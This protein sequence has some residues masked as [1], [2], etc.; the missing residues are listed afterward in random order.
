MN[1]EITLMSVQLNADVV[2]QVAVL[3]SDG[4]IFGNLVHV[5]PRAAICPR[6][7]YMGRDY[8][9]LGYPMLISKCK[10]LAEVSS[11]PKCK[12]EI[13]WIS[14]DCSGG[15]NQSWELWNQLGIQHNLLISRLSSYVSA[16]TSD[17]PI[18]DECRCE[19]APELSVS[20]QLIS[21]LIL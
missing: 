19:W 6:Q 21:L 16:S 12:T 15:R 7:R 18:F 10:V 17:H 3:T 5:H 11:L 20:G 8:Q 14:F 1:T 2:L 9:I 13:C 4:H